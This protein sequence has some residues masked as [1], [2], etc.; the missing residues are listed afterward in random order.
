MSLTD[1]A[2]QVC[3]VID[4]RA[5]VHHGMSAEVGGGHKAQTK[6]E[7]ANKLSL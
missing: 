1:E 3:I 5:G 4:G 2:G 6:D 7:H